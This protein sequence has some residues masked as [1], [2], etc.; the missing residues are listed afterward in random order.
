MKDF[1][2]KWG[3]KIS[4]AAF[5]LAVICFLLPFISLNC[6]GNTLS[7]ASGFD[8]AVGKAFADVDEVQEKKESSP[9]TEFWFVVVAL[10]F[11]VAGFVVAWLRGLV[12]TAV[13]II[14]GFV[15]AFSLL[16]FRWF[17]HW[18]IKSMM[19]P[20]IQDILQ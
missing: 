20:V 6:A 15:G 2:R 10:V 16:T 8:I 9:G 14:C 3:S 11:G 13:T 1:W 5:G 12:A 17:L 7:T 18:H 19:G 4:P